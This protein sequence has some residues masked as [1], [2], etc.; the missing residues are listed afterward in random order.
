MNFFKIISLP[1]IALFA[2]WVLPLA[3]VLARIMLPFGILYALY[4]YVKR[5]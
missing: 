5:A 3:Y 1:F 2:L 4:K